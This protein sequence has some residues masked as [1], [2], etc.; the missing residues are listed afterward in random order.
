MGGIFSSLYYKVF[1]MTEC[2]VLL[3]GL[4]SAGKTTLLYKLKLKESIVTIPTI[5]F[6]IETLKFNNLKLTICDIGGQDKIRQLWSHYLLNTDYLIYMIDSADKQRF[7]EA[8]EE[9]FKL[10]IHQNFQIKFILVLANK[11]D[12]PGSASHNTLMSLFEGINIKTKMHIQKCN[13][14]TGEGIYKGLQVMFNV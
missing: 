2:K 14:I 11:M 12:L 13:A 6:N 10:C 9:L 1:S 3:L 5:G 7:D 8:K 4:D